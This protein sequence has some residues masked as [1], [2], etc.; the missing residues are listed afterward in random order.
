MAQKKASS[1]DGIPNRAFKNVPKP[2]LA[3]ITNK[4]NDIIR[5]RHF[6]Q[7]WKKGTSISIQ[8]PGKYP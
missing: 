3:A 7:F 5:L 1:L 2:T 6:P 8:K 4:I